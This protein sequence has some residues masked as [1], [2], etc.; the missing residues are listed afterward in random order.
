MNI[1][2]PL[3]ADAQLAEGCQ[4]RMGALHDPAMAP[5]PIVAFDTPAGDAIH[6][7]PALQVRPA[8]LVVV[9]FV[10]MQLARPATWPAS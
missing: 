3:E 2:T 6:D 7:A 8:A 4:P 10:R 1:D 5:E 9:T